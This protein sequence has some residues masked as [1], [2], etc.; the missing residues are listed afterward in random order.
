MSDIETPRLILRTVPLAGLAAITSGDMATSRRLLGD[1]LTD[2]WCSD[3]DIAELR[4]RQCTQTPSYLPWSIR[5][6][7]LKDT[8]E[9]VG[10]INAHT[11][12]LLFQ[13]QG[14]TGLAIELGYAVFPPWRRR[15]FAT[16]AARGFAGFARNNGVKWV[17]L[18]IS[19]RNSG[20]LGV[21]RHLGMVRI[22]S[23]VAAPDG[24]E[25]V[26]LAEL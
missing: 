8:G 12:P 3:E 17:C 18:S 14:E 11:E 21:A 9:V 10:K 19:P 24:P 15:G 23:G 26:F 16:E 6:M 13:N 22:D 2:D 5:A 4:L 20:S 25:D 7:I 1:R